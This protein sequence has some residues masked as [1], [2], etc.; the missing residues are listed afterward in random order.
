LQRGPA[1]GVHCVTEQTTTAIVC[2]PSGFF[3]L[4]LLIGII[5]CCRSSVDVEFSIIMRSGALPSKNFSSIA[6]RV[7]IRQPARSAP[8]AMR[9]IHPCPVCGSKP[10][11]LNHLYEHLRLLHQFSK[12]QIEEEKLRFRRL[13]HEGKAQHI[14]NWCNIEYASYNGLKYHLKQSHQALPPLTEGAMNCPAYNQHFH[15]VEQLAG[16]CTAEHNPVTDHQTISPIPQCD[17]DDI[18]LFKQEDEDSKAHLEQAIPSVQR[19]VSTSTL[20]R[21]NLN[22]ETS[23]EQTI[24]SSSQSSGYSSSLKVESD[25]KP[26]SE[27]VK[28]PSA[29][30]CT[31]SYF[32]PQ[33]DSDRRT[34]SE[35]VNPCSSVDIVDGVYTQYNLCRCDLC[36]RI[37][38]LTEERLT[39]PLEKPYEPVARSNARGRPALGARTRAVVNNVRKFFEELRRQLEFSCV[40]T[41]LNCP[42][43]MT[44]LACGV[45]RRTIS[46]IAHPPKQ[47]KRQRRAEKQGLPRQGSAMK[48]YGKEWGVTIRNFIKYEMKIDRN[49]KVGDLHRKICS[50]FADFPSLSPKAFASFTRGLGFHYAMVGNKKC[51]VYRPPVDSEVDEANNEDVV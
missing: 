43:I 17:S 20:T 12:E 47:E 7:L 10:M 46:Y 34:S 6:R 8:E 36:K 45:S 50:T 18:P 16:R 35:V 26:P 32:I 9:S 23:P 51:I 42:R 5:C 49:A 21:S 37:Y 40:G 41:I 33:D 14:C 38:S 28:I 3:L 15:D 39:A 44:S 48:L 19:N 2:D 13:K 11:K 31:K 4:S 29:S 27:Q 1:C 30:E 25:V 24:P 22:R